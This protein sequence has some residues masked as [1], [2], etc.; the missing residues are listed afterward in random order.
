[1]WVI[2]D[3][4]AQAA[5]AEPQAWG[6]SARRANYRCADDRWITCTA[7]DSKSWAALLEGTG[8]ADLADPAIKDDE[9]RRRLGEIFATAPAATWVARPGPAGGIGPVA[10]AGGVLDEEQVVH[11]DSL[12][13]I[14]ANG[15][16]VF[17][18]P[19]RI[20]A[21][22]GTAASH[23]LSPPPQLG[24]HTD[25]SL[26]RAGFSEEEIAALRAERVL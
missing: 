5:N 6:T 3:L 4:I 12:V 20:N 15:P 24:E 10:D 19:L 13:R 21:A 11:R 18:N 9:I 7:S 1:M 16:R 2:S 26:T 14:D 8:A 25:E 17:A 22:P 23:A